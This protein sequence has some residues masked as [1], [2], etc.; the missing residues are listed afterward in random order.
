MEWEWRSGLCCRSG[1]RGPY[2]YF[3]IRFDRVLCRESG[4]PL[5]R[6][7]TDYSCRPPWTSKLQAFRITFQAYKQCV[8]DAQKMQKWLPY[9]SNWCHLAQYKLN[10]RYI[11]EFLWKVKFYSHLRKRRIYYQE[12][13]NMKPCAIGLGYK[14]ATFSKEEMKRKNFLLMSDVASWTEPSC[15]ICFWWQSNCRKQSNCFIHQTACSLLKEWVNMKW[16]SSQTH[17]GR[18][19]GR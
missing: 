14:T 16:S 5:V 10:H 11:W 18:R 7:Q 1:L 8:C 19:C 6:I 12:Q 9:D 13:I 2:G 3:D 4:S 15:W 17:L